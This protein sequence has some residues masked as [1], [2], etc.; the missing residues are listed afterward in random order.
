L[1]GSTVQNLQTVPALQESDYKATFP[2]A[3]R[4]VLPLRADWLSLVKAKLSDPNAVEA[5]DQV[6]KDICCDLLND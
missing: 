3:A 1:G 2:A 6:I 5:I 4:N